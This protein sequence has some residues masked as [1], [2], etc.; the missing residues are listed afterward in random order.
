LP[1]LVS[2]FA[3]IA[4]ASRCPWGKKA[5]SG[6]LGPDRESWRSYD[7][8]ELACSARASETPLELRLH[9][10]YDHSYYFIATLVEDHLRHHARLLCD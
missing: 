6:Y 2:A 10:A 3:P 1:W 7:A 8:A 9:E 5:L 4:A